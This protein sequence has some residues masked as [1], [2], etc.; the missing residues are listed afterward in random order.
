MHIHTL[1]GNI[2][3]PY[4]KQ[5]HVKRGRQSSSIFS[6]EF[7]PM[8]IMQLNWDLFLDFMPSSEDYDFISPVDAYAQP[9]FLFLLLQF[10]TSK[11]RHVH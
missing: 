3:A 10:E 6:L 4:Q 2:F 11:K 1:L 9:R 7:V 8:P 5:H